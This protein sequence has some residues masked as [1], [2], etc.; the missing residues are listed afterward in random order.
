MNDAIVLTHPA[1]DREP[2]PNRRG[3]GRLP[4]CVENIATHRRMTA[5]ARANAEETNLR[6]WAYANGL[7]FHADVALL[8]ARK[9]KQDAINQILKSDDSVAWREI[10]RIQEMAN[11]LYIAA[12]DAR[13][14]L[15][16]RHTAKSGQ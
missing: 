5:A 11:K 2:V 6:A 14:A 12:F 10:E 1:F 8:R 13:Y 9:Q 16:D 7:N 3:P 15:I 4:K